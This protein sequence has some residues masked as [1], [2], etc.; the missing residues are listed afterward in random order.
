[1][2]AALV[3]GELI[4]L[5][6]ILGPWIARTDRRLGWPLTISLAWRAV[7]TGGL[8]WLA[9]TAGFSQGVGNL[10]SI[11]LA[12]IAAAPLIGLTVWIVGLSSDRRAKFSGQVRQRVG[13]WK[14]FRA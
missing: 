8:V 1:M 6:A 9:A 13:K 5:S 11:V 7:L 4:G 2:M 14:S 12:S 3:G 10:G